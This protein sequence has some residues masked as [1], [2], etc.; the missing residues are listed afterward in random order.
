EPNRLSS[1]KACHGM[2][3]I[4]HYTR[5]GTIPDHAKP[6]EQDHARFRAQ[7]RVVD[8]CCLWAAARRS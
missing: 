6:N 2:A 4:L 1:N 7:F 5:S 8:Y 3:S